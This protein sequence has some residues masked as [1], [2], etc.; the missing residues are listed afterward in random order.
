MMRGFG[1]KYKKLQN[2]HAI[3][4]AE[5]PDEAL[6]KAKII[7]LYH[8]ARRKSGWEFLE[9][10]HPWLGAYAA[11]NS[12]WRDVEEEL[13]GAGLVKE[14]QMLEEEEGSR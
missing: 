8:G 5:T 12:E 7:A 1:E 9:A 14:P 11:E 13:L 6:K 2:T 3:F 4:E 10:E